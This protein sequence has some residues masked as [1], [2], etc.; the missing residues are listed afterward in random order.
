MAAQDVKQWSDRHGVGVAL[1]H[2]VSFLRVEIV[3]WP[4][5]DLHHFRNAVGPGHILP[6]PAVRKGVRVLHKPRVHRSRHY[7]LPHRGQRFADG[8]GLGHE[9]SI[10][11]LV[12]WQQIRTLTRTRE[13]KRTGRERGGPCS[14]PEGFWGAT[15][16]AAVWPGPRWRP[17]AV[18]GGRDRLGRGRRGLR[19]G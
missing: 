5:R 18:P 12:G 3:V 9:P 13:L 19:P 8:Q 4:Q 6:S 15:V 17:G 2:L 10:P 14:R 16:S 1:W 11:L 7:P